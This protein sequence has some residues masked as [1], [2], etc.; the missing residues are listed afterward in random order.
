MVERVVAFALRYPA[1]VFAGT[2]LV[3][4]AGILAIWKLERGLPSNPPRPPVE[5][6]SQPV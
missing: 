6:R 1:I 2:I 4:L 3:I 5:P